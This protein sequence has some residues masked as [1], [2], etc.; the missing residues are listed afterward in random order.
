MKFRQYLRIGSL[1]RMC[2]DEGI[3]V[4]CC[5]FGLFG[6]EASK[7][8]KL[9]RTGAQTWTRPLSP[10]LGPSYDEYDIQEAIEAAE[11]WLDIEQ[12]S[13][14]QRRL[15]IIAR[16][17]ASKGVV[18]IYDGR[19]EVGPRALGHRS[20]LADPRQ[21][22]M[23]KFINNKVKG[24]ESF[25]PFAP[26]C[27][28]EEAHNWFEGL[29]RNGNE[30][31]YMSI[32]ATVKADKRR[33]IPA[34]THVDGSSRLQ[35]V[36]QKDEPMYHRLIS[37]F[38]KETGIPMVLNTSF[39]T[40][41]GEPIV[42]SP[43]DAIR[44]FLCSMGSIEVLV[45]GEYVIKR[46]MASIPRLVGEQK[47]GGV[48]TPP[49]YPISSGPF[50]FETSCTYTGNTDEEPTLR[51]R[52]RMPDRPMHD[53][54]NEGWFQCTD[55]LEAELLCMCDGT[56]GVAD[57][58]QEYVPEDAKEIDKVLFQNIMNRLCRL[59]EHTLISW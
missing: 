45:M 26:S 48:V 51:V 22:G 9:E 14:E 20:I 40:L 47:K 10:Y 19:S 53:E 54:R 56:K 8:P 4:G 12:I 35:T 31:P 55:E 30:S 46:K 43:K 2:S 59:F 21:E 6:N 33:Q 15:D 32:T 28:A 25:R 39:N 52:V 13:D 3:A 41:K 44:S 23:V 7:K 36:T 16:E 1:V 50:I 24:R 34:V 49:E 27:L 17:I 29:S 42:E 38:H 5:A 57:M 37:C 58:L 11:P 18:A